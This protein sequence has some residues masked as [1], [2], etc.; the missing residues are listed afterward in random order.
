[1]IVVPKKAPTV[2]LLRG[3]KSEGFGVFLLRRHEKAVS[4]AGNFVYPGG[5]IDP[6]DGRQDI[7]LSCKGLS[8]E[9]A[10]QVLGGSVVLEEALAYWIA[11]IRELFEA[12]LL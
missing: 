4:W 11:A 5:R 6:H 3:K 7:A 9:E 2:I 8:C 1:M 12:A 10:Q